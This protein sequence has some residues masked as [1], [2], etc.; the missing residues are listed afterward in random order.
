MDFPTPTSVGQIIIRGS[1]KY[2]WTGEQWSAHDIGIKA[3]SVNGV[4]SADGSGNFSSIELQNLFSAT[5]IGEVTVGP[6]AAWASFGIQPAGTYEVRYVSGYVD[7]GP[8]NGVSVALEFYPNENAQVLT[9]RTS[10]GD[11]IDGHTLR[12]YHG[13]N[14]QYI[15]AAHEDSTYS[16]NSGPGVTVA[17]YQINYQ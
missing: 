14:N 10:I 12:F 15:R 5:K 7:Q 2:T 16:D 1:K 13:G 4:L 3:G 6:S 8:G 9:N 17:L 11:W